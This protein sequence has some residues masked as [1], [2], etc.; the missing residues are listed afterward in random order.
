MQP[1]WFLGRQ[2]CRRRTRQHDGVFGYAVFGPSAALESGK[3]SAEANAL[4]KKLLAEFYEDLSSL[5][6]GF[7]LF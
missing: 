2:S 5:T 3:P 7:G 1:N 4:D 6:N